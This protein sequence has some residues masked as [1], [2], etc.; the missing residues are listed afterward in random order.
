MLNIPRQTSKV[1]GVNLLVCMKKWK[2]YSL[3]KLIKEEQK[4]QEIY[5]T[6][7]NNFALENQVRLILDQLQKYIQLRYR[8]EDK[9]NQKKINL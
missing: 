9:K 7:K 1:P 6:M 2:D 5:F 8:K 3:E 4:L